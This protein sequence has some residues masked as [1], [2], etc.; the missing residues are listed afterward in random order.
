M[1]VTD[2]AAILLGNGYSL[3]QIAKK[4]QQVHE[5]QRERR[6]S[7]ASSVKWDGFNQA[8]ESSGRV[9]R[10]LAQLNVSGGN[11]SDAGGKKMSTANPAA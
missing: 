7:A 4:T 9:F 2:R 3:A 8:L 1:S 6:K 11:G 10:R 5:I